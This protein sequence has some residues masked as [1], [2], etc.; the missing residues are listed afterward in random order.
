MWIV[1]AK[2]AGRWR[3]Q[4][5]SESFSLTLE[6]NYQYLTGRAEGGG[7]PLDVSESR[8]A[9]ANISLTL[10]DGRMYQ[11]RVDGDRME[12]TSSS[13]TTQQIPWQ[14]TRTP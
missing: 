5:G 8:L 12:G 6:Q 10:A 14:A 11:G 2:V 7:E 13:G 9:G 4:D 1:P 3:V